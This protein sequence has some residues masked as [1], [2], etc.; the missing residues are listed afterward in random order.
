[1]H[2]A[3]L[4]IITLSKEGLVQTVSLQLTVIEGQGC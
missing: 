2:N 1:M 3:K 4:M